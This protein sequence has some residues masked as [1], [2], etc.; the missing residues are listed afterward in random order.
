MAGR[1]QPM[2]NFI[3][4]LRAF[5]FIPDIYWAKK[6]PFRTNPREFSLDRVSKE[7]VVKRLGVHLEK[8]KQDFLIEALDW[9]L[10][11]Q[12]RFGIT[13]RIE[14]TGDVIL[15]IGG[16]KFLVED[17]WDIGTIKEIFADHVYNFV[18]GEPL[19]VLDIGMNIGVASLFFAANPNVQTVYGYEPFQQ[20]Y[21]H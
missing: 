9:L 8:G 6:I 12:S 18:I 11:L 20:T 13:L 3:K 15:E 5:Y 7:L 1:L 19:V 14:P 16:V 21:R 2:R 4:F 17:I 10:G